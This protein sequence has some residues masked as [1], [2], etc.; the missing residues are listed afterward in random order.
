MAPWP[1]RDWCGELVLHPLLAFERGHGKGDELVVEHPVEAVVLT[2]AIVD[3]DA[4]GHFGLWKSFSKSRPRAFQ[5]PI[6]RSVSRHWD[7]PM[8]SLKV[9]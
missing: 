8:I 3:G 1:G 4:L 9:R 6:A 7:W 5:W 2:L